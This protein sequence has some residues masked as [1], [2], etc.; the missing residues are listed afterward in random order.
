[1]NYTP[2]EELSSL[3]ERGLLRDLNPLPQTGG[4]VIIGGRKMLNFS[5]NDYL[6]LA[7]DP[8]LKAA[9][10][11]AIEEFGA[12]ATASRLIAGD[13]TMHEELENDL[14]KMMGTEAAL[15]FGSGFLTNLGVITSLAGAGDWI[16]SDRLNHASIIDGVRLSRAHC[17]RYEHKDMAHLESLL[18]KHSAAGCKRI[19]VSESVFSMDGDIAPLEELTSLAGKYDAVLIVDEAHAIG[20]FG[21]NGGGVSRISGSKASPDIIIGTLGKS[22]GGYGGFAACPA[23]VR[24][25]LINKA[26]SFI[27]TT[28]LPPACLGSAR[29][30]VSIV[31]SERVLGRTL[32]DKACRFHSLLGSR[33]LKLAPFESQILPIIVGGNEAVVRFA[34]LLQ[35]R[36]LL[37]KPIRP[38][39]VPAG[40]A[41]VRLSLT[42]SMPDVSLEKAAAAIAEAAEEVGIASR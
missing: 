32:L 19:I 13:L 34:D 37:V 6:G 21:S 20:V 41:R 1:M 31:T 5:S 38:P 17:E 30:A 25:L 33:G 2:E 7:N 23:S 9:S 40:T 36:G 3:E 29:A 4:E 12:G 35:E 15:V 28:G 22:L 11:L 10:I 26:R 27:Y 14:A 16:F 42:L 18:K 39:T 8:R 24:R